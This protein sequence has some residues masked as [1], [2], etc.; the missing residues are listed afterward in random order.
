VVVRQLQDDDDRHDDRDGDY[1]QPAAARIRL[2]V[3]ALAE[4]VRH[5]STARKQDDLS[6]S[7][8]RARGVR[9]HGGRAGLGQA[10]R[11]SAGRRDNAVK[12]VITESRVA[13]PVTIVGDMTEPQLAATVGADVTPR[14]PTVSGPTSEASTR[15]RFR[16]RPGQLL[17]RHWLIA[18]FLTAGLVLRALTVA[19]YHPAL[20]YIDTVKYL[21][22]VWPGADPLGYRLILRIILTVGDL[23]TVAIIQHLLGLA[24]AVALYCVLVRRGCARWLAAVAVAPILLDA[25]Q[26]QMEQTIMPD[27]WFEGLLAAAVVVM[28]WRPRVTIAVAVLAGLIIG[29]SATVRQIGEILIIPAAG[30]LLI[31]SGTWRRGGWRRALGGG[32]ALAAAAAVPILGYSA[33]SYARDGHF[34]LAAG[35]RTTGRLTAAADCA[36]LKVPADVL[37]L[38]PG[39]AAQADGPDWL[40]HSKF[41][42]LHTRPVP[43]G[44]NRGH[45]IDELNHAIKYQQPVRVG[46]AILRDSVRLFAPTRQPAKFVTP[47]SRWQFQTSYPIY[48]PEVNVDASNNIIVGLQNVV[49]GPFHF[50]QLRPAFGG[51]AQVNKPLAT[52]LRSYQLDGGY[53]PGPLLAL[54]TLAAAAGSAL[55]LLRRGRSDRSRPLVLAC[56]LATGFTVIVLLVPDVF[57]FSWRYQLPGLVTLPLAG[58]L[59]ISALLSLRQPRQAGGGEDLLG[60]PGAGAETGGEAAREG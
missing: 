1:Q 22:G 32:V 23:G 21:Y 2:A 11:D 5:Y 54:F 4:D 41:S 55:I 27:V 29:A 50:S 60:A 10:G 8:I 52:F 24:M 28:L 3:A 33:L 38:C 25:Y 59:G 7:T 26:L 9:R 6:L 49:F 42:P 58:V 13:A 46:V 14:M 19:A 36:T 53:A 37:A 15:R 35:Q 56:L 47:L 51:K 57:E 34:W 40:E 43:P 31:A 45:L 16:V 17:R 12:R 30:Y 48:P 44:V 39:Q 18:I 20:L